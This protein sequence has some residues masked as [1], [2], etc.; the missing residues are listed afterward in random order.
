M[1]I[2]TRILAIVTCCL[3]V[4]ACRNPVGDRDFLLGGW[5]GYDGTE[6][7][8]HA[9]LGF[10]HCDTQDVIELRLSGFDDAE[11]SSDHRSYLRDERGILRDHNV[12]IDQLVVAATLPPDAI[13]LRLNKGNAY[14]FLEADESA[15]YV[16]QED[17]IERW[18]VFPHDYG[19]D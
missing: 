7:S 8:A 14:L 18:P 17:Y 10:E 1:P 11:R 19:C 13:N 4:A 3:L 15:V 16:V 6:W 5:N 12:N 9:Y 2:A